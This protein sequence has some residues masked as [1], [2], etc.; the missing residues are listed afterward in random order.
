ME[1]TH[2]RGKNI[3]LA[4]NPLWLQMW[5]WM[6]KHGGCR[7]A[8]TFGVAQYKLPTVVAR[9]VAGNGEPQHG[10]TTLA[11]ARSLHPVERLHDPF[12]LPGR[13]AR[14]MVTHLNGQSIGSVTQGDFSATAVAN[15]IAHPVVQT[16]S[17]RHSPHMQG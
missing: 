7:Q 8:A 2:K 10:P 13:Q 14:T 3:H 17:Q 15:G 6:R 9:D 12:Q 16:A 11:V 4:S 5:V 1:T